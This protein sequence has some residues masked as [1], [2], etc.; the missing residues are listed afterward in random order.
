MTFSAVI[1]RPLYSG[2]G[3]IY[4]G[5]ARFYA[6]YHGVTTWSD[7]SPSTTSYT[8]VTPTTTTWTDV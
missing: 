5:D 4:S 1:P 2:N 6:G 8:D 3:D 7:V